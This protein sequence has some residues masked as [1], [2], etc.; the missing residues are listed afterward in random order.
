M[1]S[2]PTTLVV[3]VQQSVPGVRVCVPGQYVL[4]EMTHGL[5]ILYAGSP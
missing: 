4:N 1:K 2:L 5:D 3:Q